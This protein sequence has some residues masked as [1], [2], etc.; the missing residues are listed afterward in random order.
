M[1]ALHC[2]WGVARTPHIRFGE[3]I[4]RQDKSVAIVTGAGSGI[5]KATAQLFAWEA[6]AVG[7]GHHDDPDEAKTVLDAFKAAGG[8]AIMVAVST[9]TLVTT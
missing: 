4:T 5:G 7:G 1:F 3:Q 6:A 9:G 2:D 8:R